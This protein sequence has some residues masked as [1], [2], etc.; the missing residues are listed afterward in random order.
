MNSILA[1]IGDNLCGEHE[2]VNGIATS[3]SNGVSCED[4]IC[5]NITGICVQNRPKI[6]KLSLWTKDYKNE[7]L[8]RLIG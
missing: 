5:N 6:D 8:M 4:H 1:L 2:T 3:I 7:S